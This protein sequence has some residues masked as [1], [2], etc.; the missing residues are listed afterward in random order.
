MKQLNTIMKGL[1]KRLLPAF[2][3]LL[4]YSASCQTDHEKVY[5][6]SYDG[7][8]TA[9][10]SNSRGP[11]EVLP[12][13]DGKFTYKAILTFKSKTKE[14]A[15]TF[16][17]NFDVSANQVGTTA[18][19]STKM[20]IRSWESRNGISKIK[21]ANGD[22][23]R[24]IKDIKITMQ[25]YIPNLEELTLATK[26]DKIIMENEFKGALNLDVYNGEVRALKI[27]G[28]LDVTAKYSKLYLGNFKDG[29][30]DIYDS[31]MMLGSGNKLE[32]E[33]K[34]SEI[35]ATSLTS[36]EAEMYDDEME[37]ESIEGELRL[38]DKYS[39]FKFKKLGN[40]RLDLYD[41]DIEIESANTLQIK[42]KYSSF[43]LGKIQ[44]LDFDLSYDDIIEVAELGSISVYE[45]K[46][47]D[48]EIRRL[49][50]SMQLDSYDDNVR[51]EMIGP[52]FK[53]FDFSGKY[54]DIDLTFDKKVL[55]RLEAEYKYGSLGFTEENFTINTF[56]EN[57]SEKEII[58]KMKNATEESPLVKV[59]AYDCKIRLR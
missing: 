56:K 38:K 46:Y 54:T 9:S 51:I 25:I 39:E 45:T 8:K 6:N 22:R 31:K 44:A 41:A 37:V 52:N 49:N 3:L 27:S 23:V 11:I 21:F 5:Q 58:G 55:Y 7:I 50:E 42:T 33:S 24:D 30:I 53:G 14:D 12:S 1:Y 16:I 59:D 17:K 2:F 18:E 43:E 28:D 32:L 13:T 10:I 36:L 20:N 15:A 19:V 29:E 34:Y 57:S 26:Y 47:T 4:F 35:E 48:F 40:A